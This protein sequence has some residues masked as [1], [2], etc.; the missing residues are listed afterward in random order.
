[1]YQERLFSCISNLEKSVGDCVEK[2]QGGMVGGAVW[3]SP[4]SGMRK[5]HKY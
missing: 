4:E 1:M 5:C 3:D 2:T